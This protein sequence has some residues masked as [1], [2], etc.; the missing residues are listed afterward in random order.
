MQ[1]M[2]L[3]HQWGLSLSDGRYYGRRWVL[4]LGPLLIF[5]WQCS[6]VELAEWWAERQAASKRLIDSINWDES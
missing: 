4:H 5:F 3:W 2:T 1:V 6:E